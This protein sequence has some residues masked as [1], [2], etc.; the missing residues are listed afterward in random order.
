MA[1][2]GCAEIFH[3]RVCCVQSEMH[4]F[5]CD[6]R[7][8]AGHLHVIRAGLTSLVSGIL[9]VRDGL[10]GMP[11]TSGCC[12]CGECERATQ[13]PQR[14]D[15][16]ASRA[17]GVRRARGLSARS[18]TGCYGAAGQ[19]CNHP[20]I[21]WYGEFA[22]DDCQSHAMTR[23]SGMA[24][25]VP[26]HLES[27]IA[28]WRIERLT[29]GRTHAPTPKRES[30]RKLSPQDSHGTF[31]RPGRPTNSTRPVC[32]RGARQFRRTWMTL[33]K[34]RS[35]D[36]RG[37]ARETTL[38]GSPLGRD[39]P[40]GGARARCPSG[41]HPL[42]MLGAFSH[43]PAP[44]GSAGPYG[45]YCSSPA[46]L[47]PNGRGRRPPAPRGALVPASPGALR[48]R[49]HLTAIPSSS[50]WRRESTG[51]SDLLMGTKRFI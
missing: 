40:C 14:S 7:P 36:V 8:R 42:S 27:T 51:R 26:T 21:A 35:P 37:S 44:S 10:P 45:N 31:Y 5:G 13:H 22:R 50:R 28:A 9:D 47:H 34:G 48:H 38:R 6:W 33:A 32:F 17:G 12:A 25:E 16:H 15:G 20:R 41:P 3:G 19:P 39:G 2:H 23:E 4:P 24:H 49:R 29:T 46:A 43:R 30:N 11:G 18:V 1:R